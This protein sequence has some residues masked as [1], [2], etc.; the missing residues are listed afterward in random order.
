MVVNFNLQDNNRY[1]RQLILKEIG[2]EGQMKLKKA[3]VLVAGAGG[4]G[5]VVLLYLAAAGIGTLGIADFDS[6][7]LSN[8]NRQILH[9]TEDLGKRKIDSAE[10]KLRKLNPEIVIRKHGLKFEP[11]NIEDIVKLYDIVVDATDNF[12]SRYLISD[13]CYF[14]KKPVVEGGVRGF[15][16][17]LLTIIPDKTPCYRCLYP[18]PPEEEVFKNLGIIGAAAGVIGSVQALE[19][20]KLIL[21]TGDTLSGRILTFDGLT[22]SFRT[23]KWAK[24]KECPLCGENPI[25]T[26]LNK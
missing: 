11:D 15:E 7:T 25:I 24:R 18:V 2:Y 3:K 19:T 26:G 12:A 13:C 16:G 22:S 5:S 14:L 9:F 1:S 8:L 20:I 17:I 21:G 10:E 6:V 23:V 4:L